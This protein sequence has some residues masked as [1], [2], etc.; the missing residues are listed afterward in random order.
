MGCPDAGKTNLAG[1]LDLCLGGEGEGLSPLL[2][3]KCDI[4]VG[5][6]ME[7]ATSSLNVSAAAAILLY[8]IGQQ[9][10]G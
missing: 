4:K 8:E 3:D 10:R 2:L 6:P 1:P 9:R 5:I 7:G